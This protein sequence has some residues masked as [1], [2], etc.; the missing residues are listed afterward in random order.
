M[1]KQQYKKLMRDAKHVHLNLASVAEGKVVYLSSAE[2][3]K[4]YKQKARKQGQTPNEARNTLRELV[5]LRTMVFG[6]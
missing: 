3:D 5:A 6:K 4:I 1:N 2:R